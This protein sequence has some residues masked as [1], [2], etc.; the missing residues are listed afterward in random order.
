MIFETIWR[1]IKEQQHQQRQARH[2]FLL[3]L[4][5]KMQR[6]RSTTFLFS[7]STERKESE[8][9]VEIEIDRE[10]GR[11]RK[12]E[13][14]RERERKSIFYLTLRCKKITTFL[15]IVW[16]PTAASSLHERSDCHQANLFSMAKA[17]HLVLVLVWSSG[18]KPVSRPTSQSIKP[19]FPASSFQLSMILSM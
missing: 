15:K 7:I 2:V 19:S 10:R 18:L 9:E 6:W 11:Q 16:N 17:F 12:R 13:R 4:V 14:G 3:L 8:R 1:F 5:E